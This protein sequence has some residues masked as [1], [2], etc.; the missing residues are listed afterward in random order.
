MTLTL[1]DDFPDIPGSNQCEDHPLHRAAKLKLIAQK[2]KLDD[3]RKQRDAN[4]DALTHR[5]ELDGD[6][7][8]QI[9]VDELFKKGGTR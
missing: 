6:D 9:A 5:V 4:P 3:F 2:K 1:P 8:I 7:R